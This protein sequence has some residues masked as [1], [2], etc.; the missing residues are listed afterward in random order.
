MGHLLKRGIL[1]FAALGAFVF[2]ALGSKVD[3]HRFDM[4]SIFGWSYPSSVTDYRSCRDNFCDDY[5]AYCDAV[6]YISDYDYCGR[7]SWHE[8][9]AATWPPPPGKQGDSLRNDYLNCVCDCAADFERGFNG[10]IPE[11]GTAIE[12]RCPN[13]DYWNR[14]G[15]LD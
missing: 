15:K 6:E 12:G 8:G 13:Y 3:G 9:A 7:V 2:L 4:Y 1:S 14:Y 10:N 5:T 11:M